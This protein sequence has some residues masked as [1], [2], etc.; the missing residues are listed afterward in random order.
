M[1]SCPS[2]STGKMLGIDRT[3]PRY[4]RHGFVSRIISLFQTKSEPASG[5]EKEPQ[6]KEK[7]ALQDTSKLFSESSHISPPPAI[8]FHIGV[9]AGQ[10]TIDA[11]FWDGY[12]SPM[13]TDSK[14]YSQSLIAHLHEPLPSTYIPSF[15]IA[16]AQ[17]SN[18][19]PWTTHFPPFITA[20]ASRDTI[21]LGVLVLV[22]FLPESDAPAIFTTY[23]P[24]EDAIA[25]SRKMQQRMQ[26][27]TAENRLPP[28][29]AMAARAMRETEERNTIFDGSKPSRRG[30]E[31][32]PRR[33]TSKAS[34]QRGSVIRWRR[35]RP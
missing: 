10:P 28:A 8:R 19:P 3:M 7:E 29:E 33:R 17:L 23:E 35:R 2:R 22:S 26:R 20:L 9:R 27:I 15:A 31:R 18:R 24:N 4:N 16:L 12:P 32:G 30:T 21:P 1:G 5:R 13:T 34:I 14:E 6:T 25:M 11:A